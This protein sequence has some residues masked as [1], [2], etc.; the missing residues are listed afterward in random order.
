MVRR[1]AAR[2]RLR[3]TI[4]SF[5]TRSKGFFTN[6]GKRVYVTRVLDAA[7]SKAASPLFD[8]G[9]ADV[10]RD[11]PRAARRGG[12][13]LRREPTG[14][15]R[16]RGRRARRWRLD[17]HRR[18]QRR[19][20]PPGRRRTGGRGQPGCAPPA[21]RPLAR[22]GREHLGVRAR[23]VRRGIHARGSRRSGLEL[24]DDPFDERRCRGVGGRGLVG[25]R[26]RAGA[27]Y[28][29][30]VE[31]LPPVPDGADSTVPRP[32][33]RAHPS[34]LAGTAPTCA[35]STSLRVPSRTP[36]SSRAPAGSGLAFVDD[37]QGNFDTAANLVVVGDTDIGDATPRRAERTR[38]RSRS[39]R[40]P[41]RGNVGRRGRR[42]RRIVRCRPVPG[43]RH[44]DRV[45]SGRDRRVGA[46]AA[47][48]HRSVGNARPRHDRRGRRRDRHVDGHR[49]REPA[50]R[51]RCRTG[52]EVDDRGRECGRESARARRSHG[53]RGRNVA[54]S[55]CRCR[56]RARHRHV[57]P[58]VERRSHPTPAT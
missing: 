56:G 43:G 4:A 9:D 36:P 34:R 47:H 44:R 7:A 28:R 14:T 51:R 54:R 21:A 32:A 19:R 39:H 49:A 29:S 5:R 26:C 6:G 20:V 55:R 35:A 57:G 42:S 18:R 24:G 50:R 52:G 37:R 25:D 33:R 40:R 15:R 53:H 31:V 23:R 11:D 10:D 1:A 58:R 38:H 3:A 46:G 17:S 45:A 8:R 2:G 48:R 13:R 22:R 30:I 41:A 12:D 16:A 27:E